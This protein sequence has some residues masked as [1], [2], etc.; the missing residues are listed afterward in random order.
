MGQS[1]DPEAVLTAPLM[2]NLA[3]MSADGPRNAPVWFIW[4]D[5]ALWMLANKTGSSVKRLQDDP[6]CAVEIVRFE[7]DTGILLHLGLRGRAEVVPMDAA[8]FR[9]L[10]TKYLG[11]DEAA[12]NPWFIENVAR[13]EDPDGRMIRLVPESYFSNNVSF[14]RTGPEFAW[15]DGD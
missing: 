8:R 5:G 7:N 2:A 10:L 4:E 9:R 3:T 12:W 14:F 15:K 13:I 6:R 1:F 11:S